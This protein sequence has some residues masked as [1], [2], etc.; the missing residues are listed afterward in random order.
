MRS[1]EGVKLR[2]K[3]ARRQM[4]ERRAKALLYKKIQR[5][6]YKTQVCHVTPPPNPNPLT[7]VDHVETL[8]RVEVIAFD[9]SSR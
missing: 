4:I 6:E 1:R 7:P 3:A 2:G 9:V 5:K 8:T